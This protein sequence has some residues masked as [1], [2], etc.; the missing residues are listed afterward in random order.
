MHALQR[1]DMTCLSRANRNAVPSAVAAMDGTRF[2]FAQIFSTIVTQ[3]S[4][5]CM[6]QARWA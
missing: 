6:T 3:G 2:G 5:G 4:E 1:D